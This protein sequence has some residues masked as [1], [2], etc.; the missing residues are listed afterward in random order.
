M[1]T[2]RQASWIQVRPLVSWQRNY[3]DEH[4]K[5]KSDMRLNRGDASQSWFQS[6]VFLSVGYA[7]WQIWVSFQTSTSSGMVLW[8]NLNAWV[9]EV[10]IQIAWM[11]LDMHQRLVAG[12]CDWNIKWKYR[13]QFTHL[14]PLK[15]VAA[16]FKYI[17]QTQSQHALW[18]K[19][20]DHTQGWKMKPTPKFQK[21][22]F[23]EW[24][25]EAGFKHELIPIEPTE[26]QQLLA[27]IK[28]FVAMRIF[29]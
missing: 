20:T 4:I 3:F 28:Q 10:T 13:N 29:S 16:G 8:E 1:R 14:F 25:L 22:Q 24:P 2:K 27:V 18:Q 6:D 23:F 7:S 15:N 5:R 17:Q 21:L 11:R 26:W 19:A 12:L 9:A